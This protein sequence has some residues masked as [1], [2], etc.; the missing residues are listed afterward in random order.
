MG[1]EEF[2]HLED[3]EEYIRAEFDCG[4]EEL[5]LVAEYD[6]SYLV[7][8]DEYDVEE[9][10]AEDYQSNAPDLTF[11][12]YKSDV[13]I[14]IYVSEEEK[15]KWVSRYDDSKLVFSDATIHKKEIHADAEYD[16]RVSLGYY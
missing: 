11:E 14:F 12:Q 4:E 9:Y 2:G 7:F 15:N 6:D 10:L 3:A 1:F 16:I 8:L 5:Y 13:S